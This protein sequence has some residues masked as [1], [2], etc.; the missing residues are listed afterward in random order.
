MAQQHPLK[1]QF[2]KAIVIWLFY[3]GPVLTLPW[4]AWLFTRQRGGFWKSFTADLRL[5][6]LLCCVTYLSCMLTIYIGQPHYIAHLTVVFYA[7]MLLMM[8]DLYGPPSEAP[9]AGRFLARSIPAV[10]VLLLFVRSAAPLFHATP[11]PSWIRTWCSQDE[12]NLNR[13]HIVQQLEQAP[14]NHLV[15]VRYKPNHDF[16]L[17]EWVYNGADID[18]S[19]VIWARDMGPQNA[20]LLHYFNERHAWIAEPDYNP[21]RLSPYVQ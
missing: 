1:L 7:I 17:D 20:E 18:G 6:L 10:C 13:A 5:L 19:K 4:L 16:I 12:Q 15:L 3:F 8:R 11:G 9:S 14:G 2:L 21:P